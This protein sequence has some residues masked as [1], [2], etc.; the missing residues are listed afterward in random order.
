MNK[1]LFFI[2][3]ILLSSLSA[4]EIKIKGQLSIHNSRYNSGTIEYVPNAFVTAPFTKPSSTDNLGKFELNFVGIENGT[5]LRLTVEKAGY[6]IVNTRDI[7]AI[8]LGRSEPIRIFLAKKGKLAEAQI[9][10]YSISKEA[11]YAK[12]N[13]IIKKLRSDT[14]SSQRNIQE[15]KK[16]FGQVINNY[17]EA[18][19]FL[20][21]RVKELEKQLYALSI[22]LA[23]QNL[24]FAS[25]LY[26]EAYRAFIKG[27][28]EKVVKI[29]GDKTL[30]EIDNKA[31]NKYRKGKQLIELGKNEF[32]ENIKNYQLRARAHLL[33]FDYKKA[34]EIY[35]IIVQ[36][37]NTYNLPKNL[38]AYYSEQ[39]ADLYIKSYVQMVTSGLDYEY[40]TVNDIGNTAITYQKKALSIY[41]N[42][43]NIDILSVARSYQNLGNILLIIDEDFKRAGI[44]FRKSFDIYQE[45]KTI[46]SAVVY[47]LLQIAS[48]YSS[49]VNIHRLAWYDGMK[50]KRKDR[51]HISEAEK[52][53][54]LAAVMASKIKDTE[55]LL[56]ELYHQR[57][58][59]N[60]IPKA[61]KEKLYEKTKKI[62]EAKLT[63]VDYRLAELYIELGDLYYSKNT[64]ITLE[65]YLK[66][67][68]I[69]E[70]IES[71]SSFDFF[72]GN[73][74][75]NY[76]NIA[77]WYTINGDLAMA[78]KF[79]KKNS[80]AIEKAALSPLDHLDRHSKIIWFYKNTGDHK[81]VIFYCKKV[82]RENN[83][84]YDWDDIIF[85]DIAVAYHSLKDYEQEIRY[86]NKLIK[87][88]QQKKVSAYNTGI[89]FLYKKKKGQA[90]LAQKKIYKAVSE[91]KAVIEYHESFNKKEQDI[92][93]LLE[94]YKAIS[95]A[96][97]LIGDQINLIKFREKYINTKK[98]STTD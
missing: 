96:Y 42:T 89:I 23:N 83:G 47:N 18:E 63:S 84:F 82:L 90:Y 40:D 30:K 27:D 80:T 2:I 36:N 77:D 58:K 35:K 68:K 86:L 43:D 51:E 91:L 69:Y 16:K 9:R 48:L 79:H 6:E 21:T 98:R 94:I 49:H 72:Y 29:L 59:E 33:L 41:K 74:T 50:L 67:S 92:V 5:S 87:I 1:L 39:L 71:S 88:Y 14:Q 37:I 78:E 28:V 12:K 3:C 34:I 52:Y 53:Y 85:D 26:I 10:L 75:K 38:L 44:Y 4:Q 46:S 32:L 56:G 60:W 24:D 62:F 13:A 20:N 11:L 45:Q 76:Q 81:N 57:A 8:T 95:I 61:E 66:A 70:E 97:I 93:E 73:R 64:K 25:D 31:H 54:D 19:T 17:K 55:F 15:L 7:Q 65:Y 22:E